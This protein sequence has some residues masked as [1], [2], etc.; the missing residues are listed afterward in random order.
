M[1]LPMSCPTAACVCKQTIFSCIGYIHSPTDYQALQA[2]ID[3]LSDWIS[4]HKLQSNCDKCK[5]MLVSQKRDLTM[6]ITLL[7]NSQP[8]ERVYSYKYLGI[9][10]TSTSSWSAHIST[11]CS[12][13]RQQIGMLYCK[14]Y[15]YSDME[16]LERLYYVLFCPAIRKAAISN[17]DV[18]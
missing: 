11:L 12:K 3:V 4:A 6:P 14:F 7:V 5:C 13:A 15:R 18:E 17:G 8:L 1:A 9:L 10:L 2:D 16:T